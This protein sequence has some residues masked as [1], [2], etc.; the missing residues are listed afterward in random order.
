MRPINASVSS[1]GSP[2]SFTFFTPRIAWRLDSIIV[3]ILVFFKPF[4]RLYTGS[5]QNFLSIDSLDSSVDITISGLIISKAPEYLLAVIFPL[6][7]TE[8]SFL[9]SSKRL[10][11][12]A[13][14]G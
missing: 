3:L 12:K 7:I 2:F 13:E 1:S 6:T 10:G 11:A 9:K 5:M 14:G 8:D 4:V